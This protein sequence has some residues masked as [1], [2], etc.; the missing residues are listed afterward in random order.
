MSDRTV[1][2]DVTIELQDRYTMLL[3]RKK[4]EQLLENLSRR[5][6]R[7]TKTILLDFT[8]VGAIDKSFFDAFL[9]P[10]MRDRA[11]EKVVIGINVD[12]VVYREDFSKA[13]I[14]ATLR[15][16]KIT[17]P[18]VDKNGLAHLLGANRN[19]SHVMGSIWRQGPQTAEQVACELD[20]SKATTRQALRS[21]VSIG[22]VSKQRTG[23]YRHLYYEAKHSA[24]IKPMI[25]KTI[26]DRVKERIL[27]NK[28]VENGHFKLPSGVHLDRFYHLSKVLDDA[29]LVR[30]I[31]AHFGDLFAEMNPTF[32][33]T[34]ET[35]NN[36]V[37]AH[38]IAQS[39]GVSTRSIFAYF[40]AVEKKMFLHKGFVIK[41]NER[42][43]I[44]VDTVTTGFFAK[45]LI[46]LVKR[47]G[48]TL[49]GICS[50]LDLSN[51]V[52]SFL[53]HTYQSLVQENAGLH[54]ESECRS[55]IA[56]SSPRVLPGA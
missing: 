11:R 55:K 50:I 30:S 24:Q 36:I 12:P 54:A 16:W 15:R 18:V 38:R 21:L 17:F 32:V 44:A 34:V 37:L 52:I 42:G 40:D 22:M 31:G 27:A 53:P 33:L 43:L 5:I 3:H 20:I 10:L 29:R 35:P 13:D 46:D 19:T 41:E 6:G 4:G 56:L 7:R 1:L 25:G 39:F 51:G 26:A 14:S 49:L 8:M 2:Y 45:M 28:A 47:E 9:V 23:H 48:G